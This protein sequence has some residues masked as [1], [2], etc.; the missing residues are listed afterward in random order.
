MNTRQS[1]LIAA[2]LALPIMAAAGAGPYPNM[3]PVRQYTLSRG[4]EIALA[5]SAAPPS[6][7][8]HAEVLVLDEHGYETAVK[9]TNGFV[10]YVGRSWDVAFADPEFWNPKDRS[11]QCMNPAAVRSVLPRYL[12]RTRWVLA[13]VSKAEMEAR[14]T[15]ERTAGKLKAPEPGAMCFM[16]SKGGYLNDAV[17]GP[18]H[19]H[20]MFFVPRND[21]SQWGANMPGS[22]IGNDSVNY[23]K[24]TIVFVKVPNWSD[25]TPGPALNAHH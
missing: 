12:E 2:L 4:D 6:I 13:G 9:G 5:K 20:V 19:P 7:A 25:G 22:P 11:P 18:W 21:G 3:A 1:C 24:T 8:E 16:M 17:A 10:C 15:A 23:E 14:E